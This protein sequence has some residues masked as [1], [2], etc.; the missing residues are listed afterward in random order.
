M[1][2][3]RRLGEETLAYL[4]PRKQRSHKGTYGRVLCVAGCVNMAGAAYLCAHA[5]YRSGA[6]LVRIFTPEENR[7]IL[8]TLLPEAVLTVWP[9]DDPGKAGELLAEA[10]EWAD[11]AALGPGL[12]KSPAAALLTEQVMRTYERPLVVDADGLNHLAGKMELIREHKGPLAVTPHVG[13]FAR[14]TGRSVREIAEDIP[15]WAGRFSRETGCVC[16]LKDAPSAVAAP[17]GRIFVNTTGNS[18]MSTGG[19]GDVL[20][21]VTAGFLGQGADVLEAAAA[22][23]WIHGRAGDLAARKEGQ[24]G[25]LARHLIEYLPQAME[26]DRQEA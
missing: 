20:T 17:D 11:A 14:L 5:A 16:V 26:P 13:E 8:Q 1:E 23:V 10:L 24:Y 9:Q 2:Q 22:A 15:G 4:P 21:G 12:G 7:T 19:S 6:G 18:G 25:L 3:E